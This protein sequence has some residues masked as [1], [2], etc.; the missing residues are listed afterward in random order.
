MDA[1]LAAR[2]P[3]EINA[4]VTKAAQL[5]RKWFT[6]EIFLVSTLRQT[7]FDSFGKK[8]SLFSDFE[9]NLKRWPVHMLVSMGGKQTTYGVAG[10]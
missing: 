2:F 1:V 9:K 5:D 6:T 3:F 4:G 10:F 8:V 7:L